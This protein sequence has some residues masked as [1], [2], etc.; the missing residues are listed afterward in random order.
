M[1]TVNETYALIFQ[2]ELA[3]KLLAKAMKSF[4]AIVFY[5]RMWFPTI[6]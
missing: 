6:F 2:K 3:K 1:V 5:G 4:P